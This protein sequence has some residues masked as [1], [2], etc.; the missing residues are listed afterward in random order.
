MRRDIS[1]GQKATSAAPQHQVLDVLIIG[2]GF[3]GCYLLH[4]LRKEG[5]RVRVVEAASGL[6]GTWQ[7][8]R[9]PG[10]GFFSFLPAVLFFSYS[11]IYP[12]GFM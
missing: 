6:G 9:Y 12:N 2:A 4:R 10:N 8:N 1:T 11:G 5:F 7:W 3:S